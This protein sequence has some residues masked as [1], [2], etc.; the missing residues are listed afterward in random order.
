M[1]SVILKNG[2][3]MKSRKSWSA[4]NDFDNLM[5]KIFD[6]YQPYANSDYNDMQIPIELTENKDEYVYKAMLPGLKKEDINIEVSEDSI[7]IS[8]EYKS[9]DKSDDDYMHISE[10]SSGKF[11]RSISLPQKIEHQKAKAEYK[12]GILTIKLPKSE[13]EVN[14]VVK[15]SL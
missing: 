7:S 1:A 4:F 13:K 8:G 2:V 9:E 3:P 6:T 10:F 5:E 12:D 14:K 11:S 15:L